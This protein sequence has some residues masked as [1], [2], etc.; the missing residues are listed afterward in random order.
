M[1][2]QR[3]IISVKICIIIIIFWMTKSKINVFWF[4]F[5]VFWKDLSKI[6]WH[7]KKKSIPLQKVTAVT[8]IRNTIFNYEVLR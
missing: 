5:F 1:M 4:F 6:I 8:V 7:F 3:Y 2:M